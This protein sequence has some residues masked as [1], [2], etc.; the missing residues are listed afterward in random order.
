MRFLILCFLLLLAACQSPLA[1]ER[2]VRPNDP[3]VSDSGGFLYE[4]SKGE[5]R[6]HLFGTIHLAP[7]GQKLPLKRSVL[8]RLAQADR[9]YLEMIL[10]DYVDAPA[11]EKQEDLFTRF[12]RDG[13]SFGAKPSKYCKFSI[14]GP[15]FWI[16]RLALREGILLRGLETLEERVALFKAIPTADL[17][18][19][20]IYRNLQK[21]DKSKPVSAE[22]EKSACQELQAFWEDWHAE[23]PGRFEQRALQAGNDPLGRALISERN[24]LFYQRMQLALQDRRKTLYVMGVGH[25]Y[26]STGLLNRFR[27]DGY[28]I[29][30]LK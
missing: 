9:V 23:K 27:K 13:A 28:D 8:Q 3:S 29:T 10:P 25:L 26:G 4:I 18:D 24:A 5:T 17:A 20:A 11:Q 6:F 1:L 30:L 19:S 21:I 14:E 2:L 22:E 7:N 16:A 15:D 12:A